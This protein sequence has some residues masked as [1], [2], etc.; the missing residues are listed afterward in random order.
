MKRYVGIIIGVLTF[1]MLPS[2]TDSLANDFQSTSPEEFA[3]EYFKAIVI[4]HSLSEDALHYNLTKSE[5][6]EFG[7]L[8]QVNLLTEEFISMK[9]G[10]ETGIVPGNEW[11]AVVYQDD[12]PVN[13]IGTFKNENGGFE[14]STFGYGK[15]L[16]EALDRRKTIDGKLFYELPT[17]AWFLLENGIVSAM[18]SVSESVLKGKE[19]R[20]NDFQKFVFKRFKDAQE[21]IENGEVTSVGGSYATP[22]DELQGTGNSQNQFYLYVLASV[23]IVFGSITF[24]FV[25]RKRVLKN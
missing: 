2:L 12:K 6:I 21:I 16:A 3:K 22:Y 9:E 13:V 25:Y 10:S 19:I 17:N 18:N 4:E 11:I 8:Y 7:E 24:F 15:G 23:L 1:L 14:L 20:L 5:S